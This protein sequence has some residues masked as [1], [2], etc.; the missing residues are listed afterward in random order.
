MPLDLLLHHLHHRVDLGALLC[1]ASVASSCRCHNKAKACCSCSSGTSSNRTWHKQQCRAA[2]SGLN[3]E[4]ERGKVRCG[5]GCLLLLQLQTHSL[6]T[7]SGANL[8]CRPYVPCL[9]IAPT[10]RSCQQM[11]I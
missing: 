1:T 7:C 3:P 11:V 4:R 8:L 10:A 6:I 5:H 2:A 9:W